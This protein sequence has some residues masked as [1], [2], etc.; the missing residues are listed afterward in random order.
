[1]CW[2]ELLEL[3]VMQLQEEHL[4]LLR[5]AR[6]LQ[7]RAVALAATLSSLHACSTATG[8]LS[9]LAGYSLQNIESSVLWLICGC[10]RPCMCL[11]VQ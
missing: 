8:N 10:N 9:F 3:R 2:A 6:P 5:A 7:Q 4:M 1:M 11:T